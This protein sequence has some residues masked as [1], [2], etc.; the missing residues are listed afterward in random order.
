MQVK[1][2]IAS[3]ATLGFGVLAACG[4]NSPVEVVVKP[5]I[6]AIAQS[7]ALACERR[8]RD[9]AAG[10]R[11]LHRCSTSIPRP[12]SRTSSP[13]GCVPSRSS[14][15][16]STAR[17]VPAAGSGCPAAPPTPRVPRPT[18]RRDQPATRARVH[19]AV[20]DAPGG[21]RGVLRDE[22]RRARCPPNR[23]WSTPGWCGRSTTHTTSIAAGR[24]SPCR[25]DVCDGVDAVDR[26]DHDPADRPRSPPGRH[27]G[28]R[29]AAHGARG[30]DGGVLRGERFAAASEADLVPDW[31][32][33]G[34]QRLRHRRRRDRPRPRLHLPPNLTRRIHVHAAR[35]RR[36]IS[37]SSATVD[38]NRCSRSSSVTRATTQSIRIS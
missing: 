2:L 29:A 26:P 9:A 31:L 13:T 30:R 38:A 27:R 35:R 11:E 22:R 32:R 6:T 25:E 37:T 8:P 5:G 7:S 12:P 4:S 16:S 24:S 18:R 19:G 15:T 17:I 28:V 23:R 33:Q 34:V 36:W 14:T 1:A 10:D 3:L 21:D 20:Q